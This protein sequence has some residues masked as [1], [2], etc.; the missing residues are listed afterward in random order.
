MVTIIVISSGIVIVSIINAVIIN[1]HCCYIYFIYIIYIATY[2]MFIYI[3]N[4]YINFHV[5]ILC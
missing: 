5:Y 4:V 3:Y 2:I 1:R